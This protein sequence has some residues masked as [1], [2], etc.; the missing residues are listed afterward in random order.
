MSESDEIANRLA[1]IERRMASLVR[2]VESLADA[3]TQH[4][5]GIANAFHQPQAQPSNRHRDDSRWWR[6]RCRRK[7]FRR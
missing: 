2:Q 1:A 6:H 3:L 4:R 5:D 7:H